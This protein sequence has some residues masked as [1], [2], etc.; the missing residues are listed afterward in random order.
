MN[1]L[2]YLLKMH[3]KK[4]G[5]TQK[6]LG[7]QISF[8]HT[9]ISRAEN[10]DSGYLPTRAYIQ[11]FHLALHLTEE[12]IAEI[13]RI[14]EQALAERA[15]EPFL[16][17]NDPASVA[18]KQLKGLLAVRGLFG[19]LGNRAWLLGVVFVLIV[20]LAVLWKEKVFAEHYV[21]FAA[22]GTVL[23]ANTFENSQM[24]E[25]EYLNFGKWE[26]FEREGNKVFGVIEPDPQDI[27][28]A[29]LTHSA[30]W[31][32]YRVNVDV[33]FESGVFEQVYLVMRG[34]GGESCTGYRIGGNRLGMEMFRFEP[35]GG[36]CKGEVLDRNYRFPLKSGQKYHM[37]VDVEGPNIRCFVNDEL[38]LQALDTMYTEGGIGL[39]AYEVRWGY[40]DNLQVIK[41]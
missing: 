9:V 30:K 40:F 4:S 12:E 6:E 38:V 21:R 10:P 37:R 11:Q 41:R 33:A 14:Y 35:R 1:Q 39:Q 13:D 31:D 36:E 2:A 34:A 7:A 18:Q 26:V 24:D 16:E 25:W 19:K 8:N 28:Y 27:P 22:P 20:I 32:D 5:L 29:F 3:R 23:Y 15:G 17:N